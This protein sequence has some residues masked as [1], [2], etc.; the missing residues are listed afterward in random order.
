MCTF[1]KLSTLAIRPIFS[2]SGKW[3]CQG[4][5]LHVER[6]TLGVGTYK[7]NSAPSLASVA[8]GP[9]IAFSTLSSSK[10][11]FT[12]HSPSLPPS[13]SLMMIYLGQPASP[14]AP[15]LPCPTCAVRFPSPLSL[16]P[17]QD[18]STRPLAHMPPSPLPPPPTNQR[19]F[20]SCTG[21]ASHAAF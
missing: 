10:L 19:N 8:D 11:S 5:L 15:C 20:T 21:S 9:F 1:T 16:R 6:C 7:D 14:A 3:Y 4:H 12:Y 13:S 2:F 17:S 18:M